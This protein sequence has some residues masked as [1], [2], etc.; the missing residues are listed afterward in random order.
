ML[1]NK[2]LKMMIIK[3]H[4]IHMKKKKFHKMELEHMS[5]W[6]IQKHKLKFVSIVLM[7][8]YFLKTIIVLVFHLGRK[9]YLNNLNE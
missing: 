5:M 8:K 6:Y 4:Y 2:K 9:K 7:I 3:I 1:L